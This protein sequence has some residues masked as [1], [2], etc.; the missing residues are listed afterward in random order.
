[1][2]FELRDVALVLTSSAT[3]LGILLP[4]LKEHRDR[5]RERIETNRQ[6]FIDLIEKCIGLTLPNL[7]ELEHNRF[8]L[9]KSDHGEL[10]DDVAG[11]MLRERSPDSEVTALQVEVMGAAHGVS[12][13]AFLL[14]RLAYEKA[15]LDRY[16][17]LDADDGDM[18]AMSKQVIAAYGDLVTQAGA[19]VREIN[20]KMS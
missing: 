16:E 17:N 1:M 4:Y 15:V 18:A 6:K 12:V 7:R 11:G 10:D 5:K 3:L 20:R 2:P 13:N 19:L 9:L 8:V 14:A